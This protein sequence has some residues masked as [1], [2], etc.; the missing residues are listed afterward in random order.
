MP[1]PHEP[2]GGELNYANVFDAIDEAGSDRYV[3]CEF[4]P[5]GDPDGAIAMVQILV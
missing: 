1:G 5:T 4:R 3:D 2:E